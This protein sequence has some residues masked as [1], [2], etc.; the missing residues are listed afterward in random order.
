MQLPRR[1]LAMST[2]R[3]IWRSRTW[4]A[5][6]CWWCWRRLSPAERVAF[7]LHDIIQ[8]FRSRT[9]APIVTRSPAA[10]R[11]LASRA[12]RQVPG[13]AGKMRRLIASVSATSSR[14]FLAAS[15]RATSAPF[16]RCPRSGESYCADASR[17]CG[18]RC[19]IGGYPGTRARK[20]YGQSEG[21]QTVSEAGSGWRNPPWLKAIRGLVIAPGGT[22][23]MV[24][25]IIVEVDRI[26]E[27]SLISGRSGHREVAASSSKAPTSA[28]GV[29]P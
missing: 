9:F 25:D 27:I 6:R 3:T 10:A 2:S 23:R 8:A 5:S 26:L 29:L 16:F 15:R 21:G 18:E 28:H 14:R 1:W 19:P 20:F 12:R 7:V 22:T 4:L 24:I 17:S 13:R 11:Q